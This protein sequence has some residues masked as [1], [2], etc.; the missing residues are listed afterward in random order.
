MP[1]A[2]RSVE[3][4]EEWLALAAGPAGEA[5]EMLGRPTPERRLILIGARDGLACDSLVVVRTADAYRIETI[6][7]SPAREPASGCA[8]VL[9]HDGRAVSVA[10]PQ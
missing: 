3:R 9:P 1:E 2:L 6:F 8:L 5:L 7:A 10:G 4:L